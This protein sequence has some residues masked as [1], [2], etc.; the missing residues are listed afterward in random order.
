MQIPSFSTIHIMTKVKNSGSKFI[1]WLGPGTTFIVSFAFF[2]LLGYLAFSLYDVPVRDT[3]VII[4]KIYGSNDTIWSSININMD[5][6]FTD[7]KKFQE[8]NSYGFSATI[9]YP[10]RNLPQY[11]GSIDKYKSKYFNADEALKIFDD[12]IKSYNPNSDNEK[13][14]IHSIYGV[15]VIQNVTGY[16]SVDIKEY[17]RIDLDNYG[18]IFIDIENPMIRDTLDFQ[19]YRYVKNSKEYNEKTNNEEYHASSYIYLFG[20]NSSTSFPLNHLKSFKETSFFSKFDISQS[21][22]RFKFD[23]PIAEG[24]YSNSINI[25]FG[26]VVELSEID[27]V[28]DVKTMSGIRYKDPKKIRQIKEFGLWVHT[29]FAQLENLQ[30]LR[31]FIVTTLWGFFTALMFSSLWQFLRIKSRRYRIR[32]N[33]EITS[34]KEE[35]G[36]NERCQ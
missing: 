33:K 32:K 2:I 34:V 36:D 8:K 13:L 17:S 28:P 7:I 25:D 12:S 30:I 3:N 1:L 4:H 15:D 10:F 5:Y 16:S 19:Y 11:K 9:N 21:Y 35:S 22:F 31:M 20:D 29:K 26:S 23:I 18:H 24:N 14:K 27:P 6:G